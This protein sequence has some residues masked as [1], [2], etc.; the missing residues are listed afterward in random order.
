MTLT[1]LRGHL[2]WASLDKRRPVLVLSPNYRNEWASDVI[3]IPCTTTLRPAP[4][5]VELRAREGGAPSR[6]VLKCE[7]ILT[8]H[9]SDL[10]A[11][12]LG[13]PLSRTR[14]AEIE[15]GVMRAIGIPIPLG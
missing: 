15:R 6:S 11:T 14:M 7:Q 3:V 8:L 9:K 5:H 10:E 12:S 2:Y 13:A 4:T 1:L